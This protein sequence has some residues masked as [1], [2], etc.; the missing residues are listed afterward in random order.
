MITNNLHTLQNKSGSETT[1]PTKTMDSDDS[2]SGASETF[3]VEYDN[4]ETPER[5]DNQSD[6]TFEVMSADELVQSMN[7]FIA[8]VRTILPLPEPVIRTLLG[9]KNWDKERLIE[10]YFERTPEVL[11][12]ECHIVDPSQ[13]TPAQTTSADCE[14]C[15][16]VQDN[17]L[18]T[19]LNCGHRFCS[20]CWTTYLT[21]QIMSEGLSTA[22][23]CPQ[24]R[25]DILVDDCT[26]YRHIQDDNVRAKY[27]YLITD[28][29]VVSNKLLK[30]CTA[31]KS[32]ANAIRVRSTDS[33]QTVQ[34]KCGY[35]FCFDCGDDAHAP[36]VCHQLRNWRRRSAEDAKSMNWIASNAKQ[37]PACSSPIE[38]NGGCNNMS[39]ARCRYSFCW[40]CLKGIP[41]IVPCNV[42]ERVGEPS[43]NS[44]NRFIHYHQR[45]QQHQH[46]LGFEKALKQRIQNVVGDS[47]ELRFLKRA[48]NVL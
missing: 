26:V 5:P 32:C 23:T 17:D 9:H 41:H 7:T 47:G 21:I 37:C 8:D 46:S 33:T 30:W 4:L 43:L 31:P 39:C 25:C 18:L 11:F 34:C 40:L 38:K 3:N 10:S 1:P 42:A 35:R 28:S 24:L 19:G 14:I 2:E 15:F 45:F 20:D 13:P 16:C 12:R 36:A 44:W 29:F 48:V 22:I 27:L 6:D